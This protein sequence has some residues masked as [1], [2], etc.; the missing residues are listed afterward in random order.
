VLNIAPGSLTTGKVVKTVVLTIETVV[1]TVVLTIGKFLNVNQRSLML[2]LSPKNW[3]QRGTL[4]LSS[5]QGELAERQA[6]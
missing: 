6:Y 3:S 2:G 5:R 1:K 4:Q